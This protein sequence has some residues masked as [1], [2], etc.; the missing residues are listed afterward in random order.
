MQQILPL[1]PGVIHLL[2]WES[3]LLITASEELVL[4]DQQYRARLKVLLCHFCNHGGETTLTDVVCVSACVHAHVHWNEDSKIMKNGNNHNTEVSICWSSSK[5]IFPD[6]YFTKYSIFLLFI[7]Y[8][9]QFVNQSLL[10]VGSL[11]LGQVKRKFFKQN[12]V[13]AEYD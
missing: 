10:F 1:A 5:I 11:K 7:F 13:S 12:Q 9:C 8:F 2:D 6:L 3:D 4:L